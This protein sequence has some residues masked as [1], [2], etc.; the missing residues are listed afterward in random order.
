M[1]ILPWKTNIEEW[2]TD[3]GQWE[4]DIG[5]WKTDIYIAMNI[6]IDNDFYINIDIDIDIDID[7]TLTSYT[8]HEDF[9]PSSV[10]RKAQTSPPPSPPGFW[11]GVDWRAQVND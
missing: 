1:Q 4:T 8:R 6:G 10:L 11:N 7:I 9:R 2:K 5:K 3:I